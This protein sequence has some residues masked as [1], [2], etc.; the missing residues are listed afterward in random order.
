MQTQYY[1][2]KL[3]HMK[4]SIALIVLWLLASLSTSVNAQLINAN[5][6]PNGEP[7][8]ARGYELTPEQQAELDALPELTLTEESL[9]TPL[10]YMVDNSTRKYLRSIFYQDGGS[11]GM[12]SGVGYIFTYMINRERGL[13][14]NSDSN[15][16]PTHFTWNF[17]NC[18]VGAAATVLDAWNII[19]DVGCPNVLEYGGMWLTF[20]NDPDFIKRRTVW[21]TGYDFYFTAMQNRVVTEARSIS[22]GTPEGHSRQANADYVVDI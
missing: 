16:Y 19:A 14:A 6:D 3:K 13:S 7:W 12:A 18:G 5:P 9:N 22:V 17:L 21:K 11:C 20:P 4:N 10:Y 2:L 8:W 15:L 1:L